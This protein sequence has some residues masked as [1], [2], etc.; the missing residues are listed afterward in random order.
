MFDMYLNERENEIVA[1]CE[2]YAI[3][4][5]N[6]GLPGH[7]LMIVVAKLAMQIE[8]LRAEMLSTAPEEY[9]PKRVSGNKVAAETPLAKKVRAK[10]GD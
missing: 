5:A 6:A 9:K 1:A 7:N 4:H 2:E 8:G 10:H 3:K